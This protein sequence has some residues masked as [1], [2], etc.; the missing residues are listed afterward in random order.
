MKK[1]LQSYIK[2]L[3]NKKFNNNNNN[4]KNSPITLELS[5]DFYNNLHFPYLRGFWTRTCLPC[6]CACHSYQLQDVIAELP[7]KEKQSTKQRKSLNSI[8]VFFF[9]FVKIN[10][11]FS[12]IC[13][14]FYVPILFSL[15]LQILALASLLCW[16]RTGDFLLF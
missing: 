3:D 1:V 16:I 14:K 2:K 8:F 9:F 4:L 10:P 5:I 12:V 13:T 15:R 6:L 7:W 11:L